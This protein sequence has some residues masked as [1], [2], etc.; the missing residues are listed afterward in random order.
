MWANLGRLNRVASRRPSSRSSSVG[1]LESA[2]PSQQLVSALRAQARNIMSYEVFNP[3]ERDVVHPPQDVRQTL[4][5]LERALLWNLSLVEA[6]KERL[7]GVDR[8]EPAAALARGNDGRHIEVA[9]AAVTPALVGPKRASL[10]E[11]LAQRISEFALPSLAGNPV[12]VDGCLE[13]SE[14][15]GGLARIRVSEAP[16][17]A[18]LFVDACSAR[19]CRKLYR[20]RLPQRLNCEL[21]KVQAEA[22]ITEHPWNVAAYMISVD[23]GSSWAWNLS[24]TRV[25]LAFIEVRRSVMADLGDFTR[26]PV[27]ELDAPA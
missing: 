16:G 18:L 19:T 17:Q 9:P 12:I 23:R 11:E 7:E 27:Y 24:L 6:L 26:G 20:K 22:T 13:S 15:L 10:L 25:A 21:S 2:D 3:L 5:Q 1:W 8:G 4:V 14:G